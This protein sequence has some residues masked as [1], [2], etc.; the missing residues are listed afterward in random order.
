MHGC[1]F[2][3]EGESVS[4]RARSA[5]RGFFAGDVGANLLPPSREFRKRFIF[6]APFDANT[7]Q[8]RTQLY[9]GTELER[10]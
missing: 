4:A 10:N 9:T 6:S 3:R 7:R 1:A 8:S 5:L 2:G